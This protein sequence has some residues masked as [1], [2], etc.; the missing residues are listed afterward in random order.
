MDSIIFPSLLLS[1]KSRITQN[2][3]PATAHDAS[4][5]VLQRHNRR[6]KSVHVVRSV[7]ERESEQK[8]E[9][10]GGPG[11]VGGNGKNYH[12]PERNLI[13]SV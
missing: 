12:R 13:I 5:I 10:N 8:E 2:S 11:G 3:H 6:R 9:K 7:K 4:R 1:F